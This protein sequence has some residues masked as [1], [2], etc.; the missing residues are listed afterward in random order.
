MIAAR[1]LAID[2]LESVAE[3]LRPKL[4][5]SIMPVVPDYL[6][7]GS[8]VGSYVEVYQIHEPFE[9]LRPT[10]SNHAHNEYLEVALTAG[11]PGMLLIAVAAI[12]V[13]AAAWR[14]RSGASPERLLGRLG[15]TI[16]VILAC[17]SVTDYPLRTP[18]L[19]SLFVLAAIWCT[20]GSRG[21]DSRVAAT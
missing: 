17:A 10:Y 6:P 19:A 16:I 20:P 21:Q 3:D 12:L 18:I 2:R 14:N 11:V 5:A 13:L 4:W 15:V 1:G 8:G 7:L 9:L